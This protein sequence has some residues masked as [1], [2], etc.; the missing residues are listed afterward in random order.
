MSE[1]MAIEDMH[2][3]R[4]ERGEHALDAYFDGP[5]WRLQIDTDRLDITSSL[6]C[7]C[8]QLFGS[9]ERGM[10]QLGLVVGHK[11]GF[12][13]GIDLTWRWV[14]RLDAW[15]KDHEVARFA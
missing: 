9:Y 15:Q 6:H 4:I 11:H 3:E 14:H 8:G 12:S 7:V 13:G 2:D 5:Y 1:L 10:S